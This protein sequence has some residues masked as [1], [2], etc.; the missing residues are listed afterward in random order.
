MMKAKAIV[1]LATV[2]LLAACASPQGMQAGGMASRQDMTGEELRALLANGLT[3]KLGGAGEGYA[4][5]V[6]LSPDGNGVGQ[7]TFEDGRSLDVTGTWTIEGDRFCRA[8]KFNDFK[9]ECET[10]RK[11]GDNKAEV[12]VDGERVGLNSW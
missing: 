11:L 5:E 3:V 7:A 6:R 9:R 8:W 12:F 2:C 1:T 10:W 4:G